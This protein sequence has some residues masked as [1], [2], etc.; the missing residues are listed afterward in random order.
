[1]TFH[2]KIFGVWVSNASGNCFTP[3][4]QLNQYGLTIRTV[5][6]LETTFWLRNGKIDWNSDHIAVKLGKCQ[7]GCQFNGYPD[8]WVYEGILGKHQH[9]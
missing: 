7:E 2:K 6:W 8:V 5:D 3:A 4:I 1:M 9:I